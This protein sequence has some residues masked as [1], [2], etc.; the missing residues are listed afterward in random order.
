[1]TLFDTAGVERYTQTIP[2]TYY[3]RAKVVLLVYSIDSSDSFQAISS[4]WLENTYSGVDESSLTVLVG[5]KCDLKSNHGEIVDEI[6]PRQ[7]AL[8]LADNHGIQADLVFE[9]SALTGSGFQE[10]FDGLA[11][12]MKEMGLRPLLTNNNVQQT[13][14]SGKSKNKCSC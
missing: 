9:I 8:T 2:P 13:L 7:R 4:N 11:M 5:N 6:V 10:M 14:D 3:R 1:M 12:K